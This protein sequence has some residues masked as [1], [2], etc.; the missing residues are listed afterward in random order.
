MCII[1][2]FENLRLLVLPTPGHQNA[3]KGLTVL[4]RPYPL[5]TWPPLYDHT[6]NVKVIQTFHDFENQ[7]AIVPLV[8]GPSNSWT[9]KCWN[10]PHERSTVQIPLEPATTIPLDQQS[11][12][13]WD[14][15]G[16]LITHHVSSLMNG[17]DRF[18][19]S[20][21]ESSRCSDSKITCRSKPWTLK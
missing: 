5:S 12:A 18:A 13:F 16:T 10:F 4:D 19:I 11:I 8:L 7:N 9:S 15:P 14:F 1:D 21:T 3:E 17:V 6:L 2:Y 20:R